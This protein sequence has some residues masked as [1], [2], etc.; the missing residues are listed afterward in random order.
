[1]AFAGVGQGVHD[2]VPQ[3]LTL[4]FGWQVPEQSCEPEEQTPEQAAPLAM[5][6]P[7]Q[8]FIPEGQVPPQVVPSQV[9]V[10]PPVGTGHAV[11]EVPHPETLVLATHAVPQAWNPVPQAK[12]HA[13]P[14]QVAV[15][16]A[17]GAH[18]AHD[19]VPQVAT[20]VLDTHIEPHRWKSPECMQETAGRS[21]CR[22][23]VG[24]CRRSTCTACR[25]RFVPQ[26]IGLLF[27]WH[28]LPQA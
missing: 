14:S 25:C 28:E 10:P 19:V 6:T 21:R 4:V 11:H 27:A 17:G 1:M 12:P 13:V 7:A 15:E 18:A 9:A 20:A 16:F 3:L 26:V 24:V 5:Q 22:S 2:V 23:R 8:S